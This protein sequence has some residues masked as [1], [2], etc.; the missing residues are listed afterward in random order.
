MFLLYMNEKSKFNFIMIVFFFMFFDVNV[1]KLNY[2]YV[3]RYL[4]LVIKDIKLY[5]CVYCILF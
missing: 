2:N 1:I 4:F 5:N 3:V